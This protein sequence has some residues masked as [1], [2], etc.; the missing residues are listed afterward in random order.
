M[1]LFS[2][3]TITR[4]NASGLQETM[5]SISHQRFGDFEWIVIDGASGDGTTELL[6]EAG[7]P[8][9]SWL[10]E[11]DG[12][13]Y[14]AM[15]KGLARAGGAYCLFLNAGDSLAGPDVLGRTAGLL[16]GAEPD[17]IYGDAFEARG[18]HLLLKPARAPGS[19]I[20]S[21]FTHHQSIFY[22]R[23]SMEIG[24]DL[25][26][27]FAADWALT[28]RILRTG[29]FLRLQYPVSVFQRGGVSQQPVN[30]PQ[31]NREHWRILTVEMKLPSA[32]ALPLFV[33]KIVSNRARGWFPRTY[34]ALRFKPALR[35]ERWG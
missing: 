30:R 27:R 21:L 32:V 13:I 8:Q 20:Y 17:V 29:R 6:R 34:D 9:L 25:T 24:Y 33:A 19:K 10:S 4:N 3:I 23:A 18:G 31:I 14:D 11:P 12:G 1:P 2:I 7:L 28:A 16:A 35:D 5:R 22:R 15:N 26:Y